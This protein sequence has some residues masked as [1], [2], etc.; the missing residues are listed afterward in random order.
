MATK[1]LTGMLI[2]YTVIMCYDGRKKEE[3]ETVDFAVRITCMF[4]DSDYPTTLRKMW[5]NMHDSCPVCGFENRLSEHQAMET[6]RLL[7][8]LC[9]GLDVTVSPRLATR[10]KATA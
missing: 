2:A 10:R 1:D 8:S 5:L 3:L 6:W 4:C 7:D 9:R